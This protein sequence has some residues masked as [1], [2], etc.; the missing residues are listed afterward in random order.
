MDNRKY[1]LPG[2]IIILGEHIEMKKELTR[3]Q[4][5]SAF[6]ILFFLVIILI[7][8]SAASY[9]FSKGSAISRLQKA[10]AN[11]DA[12]TA[13]S[14]IRSSD[15]KLTIDEKNIRS[16]LIYMNK[17]PSHLQILLDTLHKQS[18]SLDGKK[19]T[20]CWNCY[21]TLKKSPE[22]FLGFSTYY[23]EMKPCY[24]DISTNYASTKV[25]V[26]GKYMFTSDPD[27]FNNEAVTCGPFV[28]G[29]HKLKAACE[30][31]IGKSESTES[32][33]LV[34]N[35]SDIGVPYNYRCSIGVK[36]SFVYVY[37]NVEDSEIFI[38]G[39][40]TGKT[41]SEIK[42]LGPVNNNPDTKVYA[43]KNSPW[44]VLRSDETS[45]E[46]NGTML[47][48]FN[49]NNENLMAQLKSAVTDFNK[50]ILSPALK[51]RSV[52]SGVYFYSD[53]GTLE[54]RMAKEYSDMSAKGKYFSGNYL[55]S[56]ITPGNINISYSS[57][58]D[59]YFFNM[60][61]IDYYDQDY[62]DG[63]DSIIKTSVNGI[64]NQYS[65]IYNVK[66]KKWTVNFNIER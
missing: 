53:S 18:S 39:N 19:D 16:F 14:L 31:I 23:F 7:L 4:K 58:D 37:C 20:G 63:E 54:S 30:T 34:S 46:A 28:Q 42:V 57:R 10:I 64:T 36:D 47:L 56:S 27:A 50:N 48:N 61:I 49:A 25:Y 9:R 45:I 11:N 17:N 44:G 59:I 8:Y 66:N 21:L 43:E 65:I 33:D 32:V 60:A 22:K 55:H 29:E 13:A 15:K 41:S 5:I 3:K 35:I 12:K 38:N 24:A 26:D 40:D 2:I 62:G 1:I 6:S 52:P 51:S